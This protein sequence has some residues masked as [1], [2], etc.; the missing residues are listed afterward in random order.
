MLEVRFD[1]LGAFPSAAVGDVL[2]V[3]V[4]ADEVAEDVDADPKDQA[5]PGHVLGNRSPRPP[6]AQDRH[7]VSQGVLHHHFFALRE[8]DNPVLELGGVLD[9]REGVPSWG[10]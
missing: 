1:E 3:S 4:Q 2:D 8:L 7:Q 9:G 5:V 6:T 10:S